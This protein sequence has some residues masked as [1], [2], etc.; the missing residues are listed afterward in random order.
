MDIL[1]AIALQFALAL[2]CAG[3][4]AGVLM[5]VGLLLKRE[6]IARLN[7][8]FSQWQNAEKLAEK[9][10]RPRPIERF[11]YRHHRVVGIALTAGA[12]F[13]LY[14]FLF[15]HNVRRMSA[16]TPPNFWPLIDA[17]TASLVIGSAVAAAVGIVVALKPSV[18]R[19]L[20]KSANRW[21]ATDGIGRFFNRMCASLDERILRRSRLAGALVIVGSFYTLS[22]LGP[23]LSRGGGNF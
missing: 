10:D 1:N 11:L 13:V 8:Y 2:L 19:E 14:T 23:L 9:L 18:L 5:G 3:S 7:D 6:W 17:V 20:E 4:G 15:S 21:I 16:A 12:S 22:I